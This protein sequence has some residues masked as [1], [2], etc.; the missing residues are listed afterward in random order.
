MEQLM[1]NAVAF[2]RNPQVADSPLG[3]R[4]AFLKGKGLG[5]G[6]IREAF[7]RAGVSVEE[8]DLVQAFNGGGPVGGGPAPQQPL[9]AAAGQPP[10]GAYPMP[11]PPPPPRQPS[12]DWRNWFIAGTGIVAALTGLSKLVTHHYDISIRWKGDEPARPQ[13]AAPAA[14]APQRARPRTWAV[15]SETDPLPTPPAERLRELERVVADL[16]AAQ[17]QSAQAGAAGSEPAPAPAQ[18]S[19]QAAP[20]PAQQQQ[21]QGSPQAAATASGSQPPAEQETKGDAAAPKAEAPSA[22]AEPEVPPAAVPETVTQGA[23]PTES[24]KGEEKSPASEPSGAPGAA[25]R[26]PLK[27]WECNTAP[28]AGAPQKVPLKPWERAAPVVPKQPESAAPAEGE[29]EVI[30]LAGAPPQQPAPTTAIRP[31]PEWE[32]AA[33][34][35]SPSAVE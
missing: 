1:N 15:D 35:R 20:Q 31:R 10:M 22:A 26:S 6:E 28:T 8:K 2:L 17:G 18:G 27:A 23:A 7:R 14:G 4:V 13:R 16:R 12:S 33:A 5:L 3:R 29:A 24:A 32:T 11:P 21:Q 30:G 34:R 25:V 19:P 9:P